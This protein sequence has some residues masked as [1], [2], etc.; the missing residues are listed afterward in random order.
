MRE[1]QPPC[2]ICVH[3][4]KPSM[5]NIATLP[6]PLSA[7]AVTPP[8]TYAFVVGYSCIANWAKMQQKNSNMDRSLSL[9]S[10]IT[11]SLK[12]DLMMR[13]SSDAIRSWCRVGTGKME[14]LA[15][16]PVTPKTDPCACLLLLPG[17]VAQPMNVDWLD[18]CRWRWPSRTIQSLLCKGWRLAK[19]FIAAHLKKLTIHYGSPYY[20]SEESENLGVF[21]ILAKAAGG[22]WHKSK[23]Q[24]SAP[25]KR[26]KS[27]SVVSSISS[28]LEAMLNQMPRTYDMQCKGTIVSINQ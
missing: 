19:Y 2:Q 1:K 26:S 23:W 25:H 4:K 9:S 15:R 21:D 7:S 28:N 24:E 17:N 14:G 20:V 16:F 13:L 22:R 10:D 8:A 5:S 18:F 11:I 6:F 12:V 27:F 3:R